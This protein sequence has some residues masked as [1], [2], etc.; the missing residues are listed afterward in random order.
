MPTNRCTSRR[1]CEH[2]TLRRGKVG[3]LD[4][5]ISFVKKRNQKQWHR[6][7]RTVDE[8]ADN[9]ESEDACAWLGLPPRFHHE[10][11]SFDS[12]ENRTKHHDKTDLTNFRPS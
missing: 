8:L 2:V 4:G 5:T 6:H 1:R 11:F 12:N 3:L 10:C 9:Q 7:G